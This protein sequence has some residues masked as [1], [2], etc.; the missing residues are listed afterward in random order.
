[1]RDEPVDVYHPE[2]RFDYVYSRDVADGLLRMALDPRADGAINLGTG[3]A[4]TVSDVLA[5]IEAATGREL[6]STAS[7]PAEPY[8]ASRADVSRLRDCLGWSP[9]TTLEEGVARLVA[10]EED[11]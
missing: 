7:S 9:P 1:L 5:A 10:H 2:N 8:E 3:R 6:T 4:R 11:L